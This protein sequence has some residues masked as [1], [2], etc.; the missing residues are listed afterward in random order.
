MS[1]SD[2]LVYL[3]GTKDAI[4][5]AIEDKGVVVPEE[6]TFREYAD[7]IGEISGGGGGGSSYFTLELGDMVFGD[8][9]IVS[10]T[11]PPHDSGD[12]LIIVH[13]RT[14]A[15]ELTDT[16]EGFTLAAVHTYDTNSYTWRVWRKVSEGSEEP[17]TVNGIEIT[18]GGQHAYPFV[19]KGGDY[20]FSD[21]A[22][23]ND[24]VA[25]GAWRSEGPWPLPPGDSTVFVSYLTSARTRTIYPQFVDIT[26]PEGAKLSYYCFPAVEAAAGANGAS[27]WNNLAVKFRTELPTEFTT[28][29]C[30]ST[31]QNTSITKFQV[32][33][34]FTPNT[35][36]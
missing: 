27:W 4:K 12:V 26:S 13:M 31:L 5:D 22:G 2:K 29:I 19:V 25:S 30:R 21:M 36:P 24:S 18:S 10:V 20:F 33:I 8:Q 3:S 6:T 14:T 23:T 35:S 34:V 32:P 15:D 17:L 7:K 16:P 9:G 28:S 11:F 1:I